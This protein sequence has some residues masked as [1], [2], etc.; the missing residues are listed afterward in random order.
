VH[1]VLTR[2]S[3]THVWMAAG[4]NSALI[5]V[6]VLEEA[7]KW[8]VIAGRVRRVL[9]DISASVCNAP[10]T[11]EGMKCMVVWNAT[12]DICLKS[13]TNNALKPNDW[14]HVL[15]FTMLARGIARYV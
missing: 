3:V 5:T 12:R 2:S 11:A 9:I 7:V 13:G 6:S 15:E 1:S 10:I 4:V 14:I 8:M